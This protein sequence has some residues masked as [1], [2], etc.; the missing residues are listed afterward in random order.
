MTLTIARCF[1][2]IQHSLGRDPSS[3][4][5]KVEIANAALQWVVGICEWGWLERPATGMNLVAGQ[6]YIS[7][8]TDF[9]RIVKLYVP[10]LTSDVEMVSLGEIGRLRHFEPTS[11]SLV[12]RAALV[13]SG[14]TPRLEVWPTP[15]SNETNAIYLFYR[16]GAQVLSSDSESI[17]IPTF[18]EPLVISAVRAYAQGWEGSGDRSVAQYLSEVVASPEMDAAIQNDGSQQ[19]DFGMSAPGAISQQYGYASRGRYT[20]TPWLVDSP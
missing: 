18:M 16:A 12:T 20:P 7:L 2:H 19:S 9:G 6:S 10:R 15:S 3:R 14:A 17:L 4:V 8:P 11:S 5:S 13:Y 1:D